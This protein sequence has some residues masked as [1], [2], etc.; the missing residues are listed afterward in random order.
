MVGIAGVF[1]KDTN[2][3]N[4]ANLWPNLIV[5]I[6]L[7]GFGN[8]FIFKALQTI[9]VSEYT[10]IF[11]ARV[12]ITVV[13]STIILHEGLKSQQFI[14]A[15]LI[16]IGVFM[17]TYN[18]RRFTLK[19][20]EIY[21]LLAT[22]CI[23]FVPINDRILLRSFTVYPYVSLAF[24]LPGIFNAIIYYKKMKNLKLFF[25]R[26]RLI[27]LLGMCVFYFVSS[28]TYFRSL[29]LS[30]NISQ[31]VVINQSQTILTVLLAVFILH[32]NKK[33]L[34]KICA[35]IITFMGVLLAR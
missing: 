26:S 11:T 16:I 18:F 25:N 9:D 10:I 32:E 19:T 30:P 24:I 3:P 4:L 5:M 20:G 13:V 28:I 15:F 21:A 35:A 23:G 6:V 31:I 8:I 7:Y 14:G 29:Q 27:R 1:F 17:V 12:I 2:I 34:R 22:L 33:V